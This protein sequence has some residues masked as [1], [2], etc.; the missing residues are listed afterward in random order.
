MVETG[1][2]CGEISGYTK[3]LNTVDIKPQKPYKL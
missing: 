1:S 3:M 2:S